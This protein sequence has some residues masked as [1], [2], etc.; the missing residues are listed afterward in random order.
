V[1]RI[2][3]QMANSEASVDRQRS[4]KAAAGLKL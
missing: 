2:L 4:Q 3:E 1:Q